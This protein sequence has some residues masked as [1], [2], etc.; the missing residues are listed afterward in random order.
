GNPVTS[1]SADNSKLVQPT[2]GG[3]GSLFNAFVA[4]SQGSTPP[5]DAAA[6]PPAGFEEFVKGIM[7][8]P[9]A[10]VAAA[11]EGGVPAP[12]AVQ[13][14]AAQPGAAQPNA[15]DDLFGPPAPAPAGPVPAPNA[16]PMPANQVPPPANQV[17]PPADAGD[18]FK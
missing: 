15:A 11:Q 14:A 8:G 1:N 9:T 16:Q 17:P 5:A 18:P 10:P 6:V 12:G 3:I 2:T 7:G 13:P 4:G